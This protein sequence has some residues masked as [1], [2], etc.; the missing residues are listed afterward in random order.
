M[1]SPQL[2]EGYTKIANKI[3]DHLIEHRIPGEAMQ[4]LLFIIRKTYGYN[5]KD[6]NIALSQI[7]DATGIVKSHIGRN[8][9][10]L[11]EMDLIKVTQKGNGAIKNYAFNKNFDAWKKLPKKVTVTQKGNAKKVTQKG[12]K[13]TQKGNKKLPKK[14]TTKEKKETIQKK[15]KRAVKFNYFFEAIPEQLNCQENFVAVWK[16]WIEFRATVIKKSVSIFAARQ[17]FKFLLDQKEPIKVLQQS[18]R[19]EWR[20]IFELKSNGFY[21]KPIQLGRE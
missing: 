10:K 14:V 15:A 9:E 11:I 13:V 4:I 21:N 20:G 8:V 1:A 16:E 19:N 2:E 18:I 17:Q 12:N 3:L 5:K 7:S 6:D